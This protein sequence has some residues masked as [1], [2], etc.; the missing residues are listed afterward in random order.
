MQPSPQEL[1]E[2]RGGVLSLSPLPEGA[3]SVT[4]LEQSTHE[5]RFSAGGAEE[6]GGAARRSHSLHGLLLLLSPLYGAWF[7]GRVA[8]ALHGLGEGEE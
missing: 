4:T 2:A 6:V 1:E 3:L 5:L 7:F 8:A